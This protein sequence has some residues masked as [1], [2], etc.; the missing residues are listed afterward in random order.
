MTR[1]RVGIVG[2][3]GGMGSLFARFF[4]R[5]GCQVR[6]S[7]RR[8][9]LTPEA[10]AAWS[11]LL[12]VSVPI[13]DTDAVIRRVAPHLRKEAALMDLTSLKA[14]PLRTMLASH[15]GEVLGCHPVFGPSLRRLAS[16]VVV[17]VPG[18][19]GPWFAR[20]TRML[21]SERASVRRATAQEHDRIMAVVQ[22]LMHLTSVQLLTTLRGLGIPLDLLRAFSSP[23]YRVRM[24]FAARILGQNPEMYADIAL[25]NPATRR[26]L[27]TYQRQAAALEA[28][29]RRGDRKG[30]L[31]M[32]R[33]ARDF[34]GREAVTAQGR[35]NRLLETLAD[36][37]DRESRTKPARARRD[38]FSLPG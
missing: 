6:V 11:E 31:R 9:A 5:Q 35:T 19:R 23:V 27:A 8:T 14:A 20:L 30:F 37:E 1:P 28:V 33:G 7:S 2:G 26:V 13:R 32:F 21:R 18:R 17:L 36:V 15:P 34:L 24:D 29:V 38:S 12:V 25:G 22:G 4:R 3:T 16:Q 10:C